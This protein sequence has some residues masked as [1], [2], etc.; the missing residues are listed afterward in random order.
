M[1]DNTSQ[2]EKSLLS[3]LTHFLLPLI[4]DFDPE[5]QRDVKASLTVVRAPPLTL[6]PSVTLTLAQRAPGLLLPGMGCLQV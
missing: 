3:T 1:L 2:G 6:V 4:C 5:V